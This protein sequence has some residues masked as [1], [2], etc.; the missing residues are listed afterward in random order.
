MSTLDPDLVET[1]RRRAS[2]VTAGRAGDA[3]AVRSYLDDPEG[4]VRAAAYAALAGAGA[5]VEA[6]GAAASR[7]PSPAVRRRAAE[8]A[9]QLPGVDHVALLSD[10][11]HLVVEAAAFALGEV[12]EDS[13]DSADEVIEE[14]SRVA[15]HHSDPLCR[16]SAVAA[17]GSIGDPRG[18]RAVLDALG[19]R[20][21]IR[22]RAVIA[23]APFDDAPGVGAGEGVGEGE[24]GAALERALTDRDWQVRQAAEDLLGIRPNEAGS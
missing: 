14:L 3:D 22:R 15:R 8:L 21:A 11:D 2:A 24:V 7:D 19:D 17:L 16:E 13:R 10:E 4:T 6:D 23:L 5:A 12:Y 20:P 18:L 9:G 1:A